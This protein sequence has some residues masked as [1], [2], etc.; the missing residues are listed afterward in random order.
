MHRTQPGFTLVEIAI[1]LVIISL[2]LGGV[3]KGQELINSAK[4]KNLAGDFRNVQAMIYG[5]QDKYRKLPG[6]DNGA[7][8][9]FSPNL[10]AGHAGNGNGVLQGQ[11]NESDPAAASNGNESVLLW[12]HLRRANLATGSTDFSS[13]D[14]AAQALPTNAESG[15]FGLSGTKP[16]KTMLGG[17]FYACSDNIDGKHASQLDLALDDGKPDTGSMQAIAQSEG[18]TQ[19]DGTKDASAQYTD[20]TRYTACLTY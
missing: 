1:V 20:G 16:I 3:L 18:T 2:L 13:K 8:T 11:W 12:E 17:S 9:R 5:Y 14:A 10:S 6:D 4:V 19:A 15:R 7:L